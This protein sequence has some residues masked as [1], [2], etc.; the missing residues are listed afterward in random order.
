MNL[1]LDVDL[2]IRSPVGRIA[3]P[4]LEGLE[5]FGTDVFRFERSFKHGIVIAE[6]T[7]IYIGILEPFYCYGEIVSENSCHAYH[8]TT[9]GAYC[10]HSLEAAATC[11]DE[12]FNHHHALSGLEV[13][14][15]QILKTVVLG[16]GTYVGVR[17]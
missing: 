12:V 6:G 7:D 2:N 14:F 8:F 3:T 4:F 15:N 16:S 13:A 17:Q 5:I 10:L 9:C 11:G 1:Y